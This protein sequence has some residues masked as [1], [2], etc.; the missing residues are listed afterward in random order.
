M[1]DIVVE[2]MRKYGM[3]FA[4]H[5]DNSISRMCTALRATE[6]KLNR[7]VVN[8]QPHRVEQRKAS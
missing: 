6:K 4:A 3:Q 1:N 5:H 2:E 7:K 8:R